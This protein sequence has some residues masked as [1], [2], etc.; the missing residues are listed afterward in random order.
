MLSFEAEKILQHMHDAQSGLTSSASAHTGLPCLTK[1][2]PHNWGP[3]NMYTQKECVKNTVKN[4][5]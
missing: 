1:G 3:E 2:S 4:N 5:I